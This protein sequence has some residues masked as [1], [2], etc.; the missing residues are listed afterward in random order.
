MA[1]LT[2]SVTVEDLTNNELDGVPDQFL[3]F[4]SR[5]TGLPGKVTDVS[6]LD[7]EEDEE[8]IED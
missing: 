2:L 8:D 3:G 1:T 6:E 7:R 4:L 5:N